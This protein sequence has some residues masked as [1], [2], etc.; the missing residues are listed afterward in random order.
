[1]AS[2]HPFINFI[3]YVENGDSHARFARIRPARA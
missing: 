3:E 1:M 2:W